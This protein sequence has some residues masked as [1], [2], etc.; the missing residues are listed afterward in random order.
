MSFL[1]DFKLIFMPVWTTFAKQ[2][3]VSQ[4][5]I[6]TAEDFGDYLLN[7]GKITEEYKN[8]IKKSKELL[9]A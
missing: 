7:N 2:E 4:A 1:Y 3:G 6:D 8:D 9:N 5:S